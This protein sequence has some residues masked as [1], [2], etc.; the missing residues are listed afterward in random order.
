MASVHCYHKQ[1][2][3][4]LQIAKMP[5]HLT[6]VHCYH[7]QCVLALHI[8]RMPWP[9][10]D[11]GQWSVTRGSEALNAAFSCIFGVPTWVEKS[12]GHFSFSTFF[13]QILTPLRPGQ[14]WGVNGSILR[15]SGFMGYGDLWGLIS[16]NLFI[17]NS[18]LD[19]WRFMGING[20][21]TDDIN[22]HKSEPGFIINESCQINP[23]THK[24][25]RPCHM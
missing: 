20:K 24:S 13:T 10:S 25:T 6:Y 11:N 5:I 4:T 18:C 9:I 15:H 12:V 19:L 14:I 21:T 22:P 16:E 1:L 2:V 23:H 8:G 3:L 7:K 17:L